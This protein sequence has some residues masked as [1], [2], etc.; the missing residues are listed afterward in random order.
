MKSLVVS[1]V[2]ILQEDVVLRELIVNGITEFQPQ[3]NVKRLICLKIFLEEVDIKNIEKVWREQESSPKIP[4]LFT[5]HIINYLKYNH[6]HKPQLKCM[7]FYGDISVNLEI[8]MILIYFNL[9]VFVSLDSNI[10]VQQSLLKKEC[11]PK[12]QMN[13]KF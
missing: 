7:K 6:I 1:F 5:L 8:L 10:V 13:K 9:R 12:L 3:R 11:K 2:Y 4:K